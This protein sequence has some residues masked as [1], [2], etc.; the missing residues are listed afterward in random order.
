[1]LYPC[2]TGQMPSVLQDPEEGEDP[3]GWA[4][5]GGLL[6]GGGI[7]VAPP[8]GAE[9]REE[10]RCRRDLRGSSGSPSVW[11]H[12]APFPAPALP[13]MDPGSLLPPPAFQ[14]APKTVYVKEG[15]QA[16]FSF[17]LTFEDENLS[18]ELSWQ[19]ANGDSSSHTWV[20]FTLM[21]REVKVVK[22]HKDLKL[23]VGERLPLRFTLPRTLP[24]YA[25]SGILTLDLTKGKLRQEVNLVVMR[26][27]ELG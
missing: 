16:E 18:G 1:M 6:Q 9:Q 27:E 15:E 12:L 22:I 25:G 13:C 8:W 7:A 10:R 3:C 2:G 4:L 24:Q 11:T 20:T 26:G 23:L 14:K 17:P 5:L 19:Q 21:N